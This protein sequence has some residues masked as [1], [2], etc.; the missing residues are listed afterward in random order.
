M[1]T[2]FMELYP[3][4]PVRDVPAALAYYVDRL[5]FEHHFQDSP[6][7]PRYAGVRRHSIEFHLQWH[8]ETSFRPDRG[9]AMMLRLR[10]VDPDA[11]FTEYADKGVFHAHTM[12]RDTPWG[13]REFAFYDLNGHGLTFFRNL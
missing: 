5:G 2:T 1:R 3:V 10:V 7:D 6:S 13:T 4:L 11:L 9:D 8:D 12:M